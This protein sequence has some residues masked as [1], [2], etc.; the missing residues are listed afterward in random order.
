[1]SETPDGEIFTRIFDTV[2]L[3]LRAAGCDRAQAARALTAMGAAAAALAADDGGP[4]AAAAAA[5]R[6]Q[7]GA[8]RLYCEVIGIAVDCM[9]QYCGGVRLS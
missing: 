9:F 1:M 8:W 2:F 5:T 7:A 6:A 3:P 4:A